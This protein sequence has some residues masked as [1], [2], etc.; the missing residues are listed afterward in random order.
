MSAAN[1]YDIAESIRKTLLR[2][3]MSIVYAQSE[4]KLAHETFKAQSKSSSRYAKKKAMEAKM[5][6]RC[7]KTY[8]SNL[9]SLREDVYE[10]VDYVLSRYEPKVY[11]DVWRMFF[12]QGKR[13]DEICGE[14]HYSRSV[15]NRVIKTLKDDLVD[16][17]PKGLMG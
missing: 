2:I 9:E 11:K 6:E 4:I 15:I 5:R 3:D 1:G 8:A 13:I 10:G 17:Y 16:A 12:L 14:L 7:F